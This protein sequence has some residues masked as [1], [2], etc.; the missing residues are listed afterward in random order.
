MKNYHRC[1]VGAVDVL[2]PD[3]IMG[4]AFITRKPLTCVVRQVRYDEWYLVTTD[5]ERVVSHAR[6]QRE[7]IKALFH[8]QTGDRVTVSA[9]GETFHY[10]VAATLLQVC[11]GE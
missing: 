2:V 5:G 4:H 7:K 1:D 6:G 10:K 11:R 3:I 8:K 9:G